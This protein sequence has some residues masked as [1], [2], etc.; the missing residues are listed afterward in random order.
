MCKIVHFTNPLVRITFTY[1]VSPEVLTPPQVTFS[2][3]DMLRSRCF[4]NSRA[5][6]TSWF[7]IKMKI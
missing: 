7:A 5:A 1:L 3:H 6:L 4:G 2:R